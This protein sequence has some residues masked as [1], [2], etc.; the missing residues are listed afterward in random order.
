MKNALIT[1]S[2]KQIIDAACKTSFEER[3]FNDSYAELLMQS[4]AYNAE[5]KY[6]T[7]Q[8][9]IANV[10]KAASLHYKVNFAIGLYI[11]E[12]NNIIPGLYDSL[13]RLIIPFS[14]YS[15]EILES[16]LQNKSTHKIAITY[17]SSMLTWHADFAD[18]LLLSIGDNRLT[19]TTQPI[20]TFL[21]KMKHN[22]SISSF[23]E[24]GK[25]STNDNT[26]LQQ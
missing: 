22:F 11:R 12:L 2:Y 16:D 13:G 5:K 19:I 21:I 10:P 17:T 4:Q 24:T 6:R 25:F 8:E 18:H 14:D 23:M 9:L 7:F 20:D 15:F 26:V 1:V 3:V